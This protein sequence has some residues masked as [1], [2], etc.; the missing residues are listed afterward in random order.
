MAKKLNKL[1][2]RITALE[3]AFAALL[4]GK[5]AKKTKRKKPAKA[6][7]KKPA[8]A[9]SKSRKPAKAAAKAAA[10]RKAAK[11]PARKTQRRARKLRAVATPAPVVPETPLTTL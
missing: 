11:A 10:P 7:A 9:K 6:K 3:D 5:P 4:S 1:V 2:A 8:A